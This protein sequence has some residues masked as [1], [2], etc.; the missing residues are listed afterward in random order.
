MDYVRFFFG[1][2]YTYTMH[3]RDTGKHSFLLPK[4]DILSTVEEVWEFHRAMGFEMIDKYT[5]K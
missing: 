4:D 5:S 2:N 3:L 1:V